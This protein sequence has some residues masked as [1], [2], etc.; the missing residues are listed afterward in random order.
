MCDGIF[1][2][3]TGTQGMLVITEEDSETVL[4]IATLEIT[5]SFSLAQSSQLQSLFACQD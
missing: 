1:S 3:L 4:F 5:I 2:G